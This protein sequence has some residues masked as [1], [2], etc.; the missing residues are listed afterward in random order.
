MTCCI[1]GTEVG[2]EGCRFAKAADLGLCVVQSPG[3]SLDPCA[4]DTV[5]G[6]SCTEKVCT[7]DSSARP[8]E[9]VGRIP[10][11]VVADR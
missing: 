7:H 5:T 2:E 9:H 11:G 8:T 4:E 10:A 6:R 3:P 1:R